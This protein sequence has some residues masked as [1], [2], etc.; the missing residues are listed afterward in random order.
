MIRWLDPNPVDIEPLAQLDLP[1]LIA[2]ILAR[3]G[4]NSASAAHAFLH[5]EL[6]APARYPGLENAIDRLN[7]AIRKQEPI[8]VWG[9]FD[10]DGQTATAVLVKTLRTLGARVDFHIP[11]RANEGHGVQVEALQAVLD[12]GASLVL[13]CDTGI[14]AHDA[15][16]YANARGVDIIIT[17]HHD[18]GESLPHAL[19]VINPKLLPEGDPMEHLAG[20]GV[21]YKLAEALLESQH[22]ESDIG[23]EFVGLGL[24]ADLAL[25]RGET[26]T[27]AYRGIRALRG[28]SNPGLE[29]VADL[30]NVSLSAATDET[31]GYALAPRLNAV[32]RLGDAHMAV[33]L[34]LTEDPVRARVLAAEMEGLNTE[35]RLLTLQVAAAAEQQLAA[36]PATAGKAVLVL[37]QETW[38]AGV[39]GIVAAR[40]T[41]RYGKPAILLTGSST[42][43]LR[44]SARSIEG[45]H[46][47]KAIAAQRE[48]LMAF[49][50]HPMAAGLSLRAE[51]LPSFLRGIESTVQDLVRDSGSAEAQLQ[52]EEWLPLSDI[53]PEL[54]N[55]MELLAPYG[56]GNRLPVLATQAVR[57]QSSRALGV[58][59]EH[60]KLVV[61][62]SEGASAE[63]VWWNSDVDQLPPE[64]FDLAYS[65]RASSFQGSSGV[66]AQVVDFRKIENLA[67]HVHERSI[68]IVDLRR[69]T[70]AADIPPGCLIWAEGVDQL[71]GVDRF[72]L[73]PSGDFA[74]WTP[75]ASPGILRVALE[76]V[77]PTRVLVLARAGANSD[78]PPAFLTRLAGLARFALDRKGGT[79]KISQLAAACAQRELTVFLG[80]EWLA[81]G[82]RLALRSDDDAVELT[83]GSGKADARRQHDLAAALASLVAETAAYR[84]HFQSA[85][86]NALF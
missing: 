44:G 64:G 15:V 22:R 47:T 40:L 75:P 54:A 10:A 41:Q 84:L 3:R 59:R 43:V 78:T 14:V 39:L 53:T 79:A 50:G 63:V 37:H 49:G 35:R 1:L 56:A 57:L 27:L 16:A 82:G 55:Q 70:T 17:D 12:A 8:C 4:L 33:E 68:E 9:D 65:V 86:A 85:D 58:A 48:H 74:I 34:L 66:S 29:A 19:A 18:L 81:A 60:H 38:P 31:I 13:T 36:S 72:H 5:P 83:R 26:R 21:A 42:G 62:N 67:V 52:I 69:A 28:A 25:L 11:N 77:R 80:L 46:I 32:G 51:M 20:V 76:T 71:H 7:F 2:Q 23:L 45:V 73:S 61:V 6:A 24:I 30:A